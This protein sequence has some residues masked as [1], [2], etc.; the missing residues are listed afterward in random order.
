LLYDPSPYAIGFEP[1][2]TTQTGVKYASR[3]QG[4]IS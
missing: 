4:D 1:A 3:V 2:G